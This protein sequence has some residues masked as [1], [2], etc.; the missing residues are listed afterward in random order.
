MRVRNALS[1]KQVEVNYSYLP[2][3]RHANGNR[4]QRHSVHEIRRAIDWIHN[5]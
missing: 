1:V 4:R 3:I 2:F 5:P